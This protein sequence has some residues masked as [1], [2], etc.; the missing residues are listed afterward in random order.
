MSKGVK[1]TDTYIEK[2]LNARFDEYVKNLKKK[3]AGEL[4]ELA[5]DVAGNLADAAAKPTPFNLIKCGINIWKTMNDNQ[6]YAEEFFSPEWTAPFNECFNEFVVSILEDLP[7]KVIKTSE[8]ERLIKIAQVK[9]EEI[10]WILHTTQGEIQGVYVRKERKTEACAALKQAQWEKVSHRYIVME[11][12]PGKGEYSESIHFK[13]DEDIIGLQSKKADEYS[14]YLKRCMDAGVART[15]LFYGP[16]GTGKSTI[17]RAIADR[18]DLRTLRI[19]VEDIGNFDNTVIFEAIDI[20]KPD[21]IILDDLD[22]AMQQTHLLETMDR[23]HKHIK[24]VFATVNHQEQLDDALLRPGRFDE[25]IRI[26]RLDDVVIRNL[27]GAANSHM[28][29]KVKDWPVAFVQEYV[30]RRRFMSEE[31]ALRACKELQK[32]VD[33]LRSYDDDEGDDE[34]ESED[35]KREDSESELLEM[36]NS[37]EEGESEE[38]GDEEDE[39][40]GEEEE[41]T[42]EEQREMKKNLPVYIAKLMK[43]HKIRFK[44][45]K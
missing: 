43:K 30:T 26:R 16:P 37:S 1:E 11:K 22:R 33:K 20:F 27:L 10:G 36:E 19:R 29:E 15:I 7:C 39:D 3:D 38:E 40:V 45:M 41:G 31:D 25:I 4:L 34:D 5:S 42:E 24:L 35:E 28:F 23:F 13:K 9:C 14:Q 18:L 12:I 32:R 6:M 44:F 8:E 2:S 17:A 21:A